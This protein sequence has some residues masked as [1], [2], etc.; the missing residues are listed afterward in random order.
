MHPNISKEITA[1]YSEHMTGKGSFDEEHERI[2]N[3]DIYALKVNGPIQREMTNLSIL[4]NDLFTY[5]R[6]QDQVLRWYSMQDM[7]TDPNAT[8]TRGPYMS[9]TLNQG[10]CCLLSPQIGIDRK[11]AD[12]S[13]LSMLLTNATPGADSGVAH[14]LFF[15]LDIESYDYAHIDAEGVGA[16]V[17]FHHHQDKPSV[18]D[19]SAVMIAPGE[20]TMIN[21]KPSLYLTTPA[22]LDA[23]DP[24]GRDC[25]SDEDDIELKFTPRSDG[26]RY[27]M[28]NCL[29]NYKLQVTEEVCG[30]NPYR[31]K[32]MDPERS[33]QEMCLGKNI[34]CMWDVIGRSRSAI[35]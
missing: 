30:C 22:A 25:F 9:P 15:I 4:C 34:G 10:L 24:K 26:Y 3:S 5:V 33:D 21:M 23:F 7:V 18:S 20:L 19:S 8:F 32:I 16:R 29:F 35:D 6:Y 17:F 12:Y 2:I 1:W 13:E 27:S 14:G 11:W 28:S 31:N